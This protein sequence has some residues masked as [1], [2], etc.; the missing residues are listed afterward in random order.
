VR[1]VAGLSAALLLSALLLPAEARAIEPDFQTEAA[2]ILPGL[3]R[4]YEVPSAAIAV[5]DRGKVTWTGRFDDVGVFR[6][7]DVFKVASL[8]KTATALAVMSLAEQG[9]IDLD[10]PVD[11]YLKRWHVPRSRFDESKVT[12]R[13]VMSHTAGFP[14]SGGGRPRQA[15]YPP[16]EEIL[17]G[18]HSLGPATLVYE[19]GSRFLYSNPGYVVLELLVEEVTRNRFPEAMRE[20]VFEPLAMKDTGYDDDGALVARDVPGFWRTGERAGEQLRVP[21]GPGGV[22]ST[23]R[24]IARLLLAASVPKERGGLL[25]S[26][27]LRQ[28]QTVQK[29]ARGAFGLGDDGGYALGIAPLKLPSGRS[30]MTNNGSFIGY[31]SMMFGL[32]EERSGLVVL[33]NSN[34]GIGIELELSLEWLDSVVGE[35]P[36]LVSR[37]SGIRTGVRFATLALLILFLVFLGRTALQVRDGRRGWPG[38]VGLR[39]LFLK[40][41]PLVAIGVVLFLVIGTR[42]TTAAIGGIP[43]ARFVSGDYQGLITGLSLALF[44][45]GGVATALPKRRAAAD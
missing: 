13:R 8:S 11:G 24:D 42:L 18:N 43:P 17:E 20:L 45:V 2:R 22:L 33:T 35:R 9:R 36:E 10:A 3:L 15:T 5:V 14:V 1:R 26:N 12:A 23:P 29:T 31:N 40:T 30:L 6:A 28:M 44:A 7:G 39:K 41:L 37:L 38:N 4:R 27:S 19:P 34:T 32:P 21:R 16:V 25:R